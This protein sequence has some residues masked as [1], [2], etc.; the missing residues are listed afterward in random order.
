[1]SNR[2][3]FNFVQIMVETNYKIKRM[4]SYKLVIHVLIVIL[5]TSRGQDTYDYCMDTHCSP[6]TFIVS[7]QMEQLRNLA[8]THN[9]TIK[10]ITRLN[11]VLE[12]K[13]QEL[14]TK[15]DQNEIEITV[16][17]VSIIQVIGQMGLCKIY[18]C[19]WCVDQSNVLWKILH[20]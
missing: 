11:E 16:L 7:H 18:F 2:I 15:L 9:Q 19:N 3:R 8:L 1:M 5:Q 10:E 14:Q 12:D 20:S 13:I 17:K 6:E 4:M